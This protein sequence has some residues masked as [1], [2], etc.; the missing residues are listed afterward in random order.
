[1]KRCQYICLFSLIV[2][3]ASALSSP[4]ALFWHESF[5]YPLGDLTNVAAGTWIGFSGA[6]GLNVVSGN[7]S[8]AGY[9]PAGGA[10]EFGA[11]SLDARRAIPPST[12][13]Y[14]SLLVRCDKIPNSNTYI[15]SFY[16]TAVGYVVRVFAGN[17]ASLGFVRYGIASA[18]GTTV[19]GPDFP[20]GTIVKLTIKYDAAA[21]SAALWFNNRDLNEHAP[22]LSY[23]AG[24]LTNLVTFFAIRQGD[25][26]HNGATAFLIDEIRVGNSWQD[27]QLAGIPRLTITEIMSNSRNTT[28]NGDWFE[29][30]NADVSNVWLGGF[31]FDDSHMVIGANLISGIALAPGEAFIVYDTGTARQ[32]SAFYTTWSLTSAVQVYGLTFANGLGNGDSVYIWDAQSNLVASQSYPS[33]QT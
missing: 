4:A 22:H 31:T 3:L 23:T 18:G 9:A 5:D 14:A 11:A 20:T 33:K 16:N 8:F 24:N 21:Q 28:A 32:V 30:Y 1:M 19:W 13:A 7:L 29:V 15:F 26:L 17:G 25:P 12:L 10:L 2:S 27:V 6:G